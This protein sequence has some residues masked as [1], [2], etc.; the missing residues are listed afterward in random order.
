MARAATL[1]VVAILL[2]FALTAIGGYTLY[3]LSGRANEYQLGW[4]SN[5][6]LSP[7]IAVIVGSIVGSHSKKH[8]LATALFGLAPWA[9]SL[10]I[11]SG[12][13]IAAGVGAL[14]ELE[15]LGAVSAV[16]SWRFLAR[17]REGT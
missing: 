13:R 5:H 15:I 2:S 12:E 3:H 9:V 6:L 10:N 4:F 8:A 11:Y 14:L 17:R 16:V 7:C 1:I